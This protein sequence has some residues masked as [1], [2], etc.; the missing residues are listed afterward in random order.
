MIWMSQVVS[1]LL[2]QGGFSCIAKGEN[3]ESLRKGAPHLKSA[4]TENKFPFLILKTEQNR[5][6]THWHI[7]KPK[8]SETTTN[9]KD[10]WNVGVLQVC[11]GPLILF[12]SWVTSPTPHLCLFQTAHGNFQS[13]FVCWLWKKKS[14]KA[15][16]G[17][18]FQRPEAVL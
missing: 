9:R 14:G 15:V 10:E 2:D 17:Y 7:L 8:M 1:N 3:R 5:T 16:F 13:W 12:F 6:H 18:K 4:L 11:A